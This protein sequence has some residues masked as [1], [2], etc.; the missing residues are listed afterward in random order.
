M[1]EQ[2]GLIRKLTLQVLERALQDSADWKEQGHDPAININLSVFCLQDLSLPEEINAVLKTYGVDANKIEMEITETAL[3][4]NL[5]RARKTLDKL[6]Q[7]GLHLAI[8]DFGTGFSSLNYLK[9]LPVDTLKIDKSFVIDMSINATDV[10][11]IKT[12]IELAHN[13]DCQVVAEGVEDQ[14]TMDGLRLL[15]VDIIQGHYFSKP[16]AADEMIAWLDDFKN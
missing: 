12:I 16:M 1:A 6:N 3:M 15:D 7:M 4:H 8:D 5:S 2:M 13:L 9:N 14:S 10:A 11:V